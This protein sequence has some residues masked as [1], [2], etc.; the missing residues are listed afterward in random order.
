M[1]DE[2]SIKHEAE[3]SSAR[4]PVEEKPTELS[5]A[6]VTSAQ[7][8]GPSVAINEASRLKELQ[9]DVRDQDDLERDIA[10]QASSMAP[11]AIHFWTHHLLTVRAGRQA[12]P[13]TGR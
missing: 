7:S 5:D 8:S 9:A 11:H 6:A 2:T 12:A 13:G 3:G 10:R 1:D 4:D